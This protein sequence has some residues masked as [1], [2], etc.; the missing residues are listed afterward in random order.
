MLRDAAESGYW[1]L[2]VARVENLVIREVGCHTLKVV[3]HRDER[4]GIAWSR[5]VVSTST[6]VR[7]FVHYHSKLESLV[8]CPRERRRWR[9]F[10]IRKWV[11]TYFPQPLS[12]DVNLEFRHCWLSR[13]GSR[14]L[15]VGWSLT[16]HDG[17]VDSSVNSIGDVGQ[18]NNLEMHTDTV[19]M[20]VV[21]E[22][23]E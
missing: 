18:G 2:T 19:D 1:D 6:S 10:V 9:P 14:I 4:T 16:S 21:K 5:R 12:P 20:F 7:F 8:H 11:R 23:K 13:P 17:L 22:G 3:E 15:A